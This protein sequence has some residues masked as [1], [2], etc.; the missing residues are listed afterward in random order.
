MIVVI[1]GGIFGLLQLDTSKNYIE[2]QIIEKSFNSRYQGRIDIGDLDGLMP[3]R[4][5]LDEVAITVPSGDSAGIATDSVLTLT[6][7]ETQIDLWQLLQNKIS[8]NAFRVQD[9]RLRLLSD[10][11]YGYSLQRAFKTRRSVESDSVP[12]SRKWIERIEIIAPLLTIQNGSVY[13]DHLRQKNPAFD[14]PEPFTVESINTTMF[15]EISEIQRFLDFENF[16][17]ELPGL[18][19]GDVS[20]SGQIYN[21][22]RFLEFNAFNIVTPRSEL[23]VSGQIDGINIEEGTIREQLPYAQYDLDVN[24]E[25]VSLAEFSDVFPPLPAVEESLDFTVQAEGDMDSLWIDRFDFGVGESIVSINGLIR[26]LNKKDLMDYRFRV[27]NVLLRGRDVEVFTGTLNP[28]Q[29]EVLENLRFGGSAAGN[30]DSLNVDL[31]LESPNGKMDLTGYARLSDPFRYNASITASQLNFGPFFGDNIDTTSINADATLSGVGYDITRDVH[32][33]TASMY[34][35]SIDE[36]G[37]D[38]LE[39]NATFIDGF[40]EHQY[41]YVNDDERISGSGWIDLDTEEAQFALKGQSA[42]INLARYFSSNQIPQTRLNV[43]YNVEFT[44]LQPDRVQGRANLDVN[45]SFIDGDTVR[46]HQIYMDLDSPDLE[47]RTFRLTSSLFDMNLQ[48]TIKPSNLID[49]ARYWSG[50]LKRRISEEILMD[51][52]SSEDFVSGTHIRPEPLALTGNLVTKD[53]GL[54]KTYWEAFPQI[55]ADSRLTFDLKADS[56]RFLLTTDSRIDTLRY[57]SVYSQNMTAR[58]TMGFRY[59]RPL[60]EFANVDFETT[61]DTIHTG[62]VDVESVGLNFSIRQDSVFFSQRI[63]RISEDARSR[64]AFSASISH[65]DLEVSVEEFF[66][67]NELYAWQNESK[68]AITFS[69]DGSIAFDNF[70]FKNN[71]EYLEI[72]GKITENREDS[73]LFILRDVNLQRISELV[74]GRIGFD[75]RMNGTLTGRSLLERPSLQG[76][77]N[78]R[79]LKL[80][81]RLVGDATFESRFNEQ[82]NRFDTR[83]TIVTDSTKYGDYLA[84]NDDIGQQI[85]LDG[86]FHPPNPQADQDTVFYF[87]A[88]FREIDLWIVPQIAPKVFREVEGRATGGGYITGNLEDYDFHFDFQVE[89]AFAQPEFLNTNYFVG[90]HVA[91]DRQAWVVFDSLDV[92]DTKGG[93]GKL[94]GSVD[95][96]NFSP[97]NNMDLT[98]EMQ[99]LHFLNNSYDPDVPFYGSISG[100]G[101]VHLAG[102]N[103]NLFLRTPKTIEV[104]S[105]SKLSIPLLEETELNQNT[106]FIQFVDKFHQKSRTPDFA[107]NGYTQQQPDRATINQMLENLSFSERFNLDLQFNTGNPMTVELIFDQVTGEVLTAQGT[108]QLRLTME[109]ENVQMFGRY[110]IDSGSYQFVGGEIFTRRLDLEAGGTIVWEGDPEN[111]RLNINAIY[112]ARPSTAPLTAGGSSTS[113]QDG[114]GGQRIP[115]ELVVEIRGTLSSVENNYYFRLPNTFDVSSNTT[116]TARINELNR[117]EQQKLIQA[118]SILL[119]G[120]FIAYQDVNEASRN[121]GQSFTKGSTYLNPL[122]SSQVISPLLSNQINNLLNSDVSRLDIDFSLN[123]Y[124][125]IDLGVALRLYNDRL[126][127]RREGLITSTDNQASL[128]ERIGDLN[129]TY[130]INRGLSVTAFHRQDQTLSNVT[131]SPQAGDVSA[132]VDGIGLEAQVEFNTWKDLT[133]KIKRTFR[134][135]FGAGKKEEEQEEGK[136]DKLASENA[137]EEE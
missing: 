71:N 120:N 14:L 110:N 106:K 115:I 42:N 83:I 58:L 27:R 8:I 30:I 90:G 123:T 80:D 22:R 109:E 66:F 107:I 137:V 113:D 117:D 76:E 50:Y 54:L 111:A 5:V 130:R 56:S 7:L 2:T 134:R 81:D 136:D 29:A 6:R 57:R 73:V 4:F 61:I 105:D 13:V 96:N 133:R 85:Y 99:S 38:N 51:S 79:R 124:N 44:G 26:N 40:L 12:L 3:F 62:A 15:L 53:L 114:P 108:G 24:S 89:N 32:N 88:N 95:L 20:F 45:E 97:I 126:I 125:E 16:T 47:S 36:V 21:D 1:G 98:L 92:T 68:P 119:T 72:R 11:E 60:R 112:N 18:K 10:S 104:T 101:V 118:T 55:R 33:I 37:F 94:Y 102:P 25:K 86:Y 43:D 116:L 69:R 64:M 100:T 9:P 135:I 39:L 70:R 93:S 41:T 78:I 121:I 82:K 52:T 63:G 77:L 67:G 84:E 127:L 129:A 31:N 87:D 28:T 59:G 48:G 103:N 132:T 131:P 34:N 75:G 128:T 23:V 65:S 17:A 74:N 49:H 35:S 46:A 19:V 122:L 91:F